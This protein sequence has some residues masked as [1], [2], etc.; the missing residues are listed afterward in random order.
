MS[1][2]RR[3]SELPPN[4]NSDAN[5]GLIITSFFPSAQTQNCIAITD[6]TGTPSWT[7]CAPGYLFMTHAVLGDTIL[8]LS[9]TTSTNYAVNE[10]NLSG[11][12]LHSLTESAANIQLAT[13]KQ[14]PIIDFNHEAFRL[15]NGYTAVIAHNERLYTDIQG[16]TGIV[17]ILGDEILVL[18]TQWKIVWT[19]NAFDFLPVTRAAVL[20]ETCTPCP[21]ANLGKCCPITLAAQANDWLHGNSL[22]YDSTD[23]N[24]ILS[25]RNQDWIVEDRLSERNRRRTLDLDPRQRRQLHHDQHAPDSF[26]WFSHQHDVGIQATDNPKLLTLFDNGN[27]REATDPTAKS[28]GQVLSID[29]PA[30]TA[31]I[32]FNANLPFYSAGYGTAQMLGKRQLLV[33]GRRRQAARTGG[34]PTRS[35]EFFPSGYT[36][37]A[38]F[39]IEFADTAYRSF[40]LDNAS[41]F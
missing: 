41:G 30:L 25:I 15:P 8:F 35:F 29:E 13:L 18:N 19:W 9:N 1:I 5:Q 40:R 38:A 32:H 39:G 26:P 16:S 3:Q 17:D 6:L 23:G 21:E 11:T 27:T 28:R 36:G 31:D 4:K 2:A 10:M 14:Q 20:G 34:Y 12:I 24:L 22:T 33:P 37:T 7:Y